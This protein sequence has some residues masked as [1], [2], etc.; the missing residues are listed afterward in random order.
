MKEKNAFSFETVKGREKYERVPVRAPLAIC[1]CTFREK[2]RR[3]E[4]GVLGVTS[5][6]KGHHSPYGGLCP[7]MRLY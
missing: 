3:E 5:T 4:K 2:V 1:L 7:A 6:E